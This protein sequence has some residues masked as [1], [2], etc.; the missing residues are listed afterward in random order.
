MTVRR[1]TGRAMPGARGVMAAATLAVLSGCATT[2]GPAGGASI[3]PLSALDAAAA[4]RYAAAEAARREALAPAGR[5]LV[6]ARAL[7]GR[8][9]VRNGQDG[10]S[11]RLDWRQADGTLTVELSAPVTRQGWRL[12][13]DASGARL[14]GAEGGPRSGPD[15]T[16]L[17]REVTGW[18]VPIDALACWVV[19]LPA[20]AGAAGAA[21]VGVRAGPGGAFRPARIRQGGWEILLEDW[22]ADGLPARLSAQRD[23]VSLRLVV[24]RRDGGVP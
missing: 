19:G 7:S 23:A 10:G 22:T 8:V 3:I 1:A 11:G 15:A 9:A 13:V 5:C 14:D 20:D 21:E 6:P 4:D 12:E 16:A 18:Q 2:G 24:D 17:L